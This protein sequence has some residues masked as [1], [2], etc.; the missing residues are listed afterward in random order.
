MTREEV[1]KYIELHGDAQ[2]VI[3]TIKEMRDEGIEITEQALDERLSNSGDSSEE[4]VE[5]TEKLKKPAF[6]KVA[7]IAVAFGVLMSIMIIGIYWM[8]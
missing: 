1:K 6:I 3:E 7:G 2:R 4:P 5:V 8:M